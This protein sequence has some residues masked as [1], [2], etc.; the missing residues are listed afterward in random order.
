MEST[1]TTATSQPGA[2]TPA[3]SD[4]KV[5]N[6]IVD[7]TALISGVKRNTR[8]GIKKWIHNGSIRL[9][10][11]LHTLKQLNTLRE[12]RVDR[13]GQDAKDTLVWLDQVT[14]QPNV[15]NGEWVK[16]QEGH[17]EYQTWAEVEQFLLPKTLLAHAESEAP[18]NGSLDGQMDK[19]QIDDS[20]ASMSSK[21]SDDLRPVTPSSPDSTFSATSPGALESSPYKDGTYFTVS[22]DVA[23]CELFVAI[24]R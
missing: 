9:V 1:T 23:F 5:F 15:V 11:P 20:T 22:E 10:V 12:T 4:R 7:A 16:I 2:I 24:I 3:R 19:L 14:E 8:D 21:N 13:S 18:V 17:E 6:V